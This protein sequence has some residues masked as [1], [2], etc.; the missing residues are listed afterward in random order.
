MKQKKRGAK[1]KE[2]M[3][4]EER[5]WN[6]WRF[7]STVWH[8]SSKDSIPGRWGYTSI[9]KL[10]K[11]L[12]LKY[13]PPGSKI[14]CFDES[15]DS[16][17]TSEIDLTNRIFSY[18]DFYDF[19]AMDNSE[20]T[21]AKPN[22]FNRMKFDGI[23]ATLPW[24]ILVE[25][26]W[27]PGQ[28]HEATGRF[29]SRTRSL[30]LKCFEIIQDNCFF[31]LDTRDV[32]MDHVIP[33]GTLLMQ[34]SLDAGFNLW[35]V[36][37]YDVIDQPSLSRAFS[38]FNY[39]IILQKRKQGWKYLQI[40]DILDWY[41]EE[42]RNIKGYSNARSNHNC[43][44]WNF[45]VGA[46]SRTLTHGFEYHSE[47]RYIKSKRKI[48]EKTLFAGKLV[49]QLVRKLI[50]EYSQPNDMLFD[51]FVGTGTVILE[52]VHCGRKSFGIDINPAAVE[53][54]KR[55]VHAYQE[56]RKDSQ[57][58][59]T[60]S[61]EQGNAIEGVDLPNESTDLVFIHPPYWG[62]VKYTDLAEDLSNMQLEGYLAAMQEVLREA[63]RILKSQG[64]VVVVIGDK[65][66]SGLVPLGSYLGLLGTYQGF[67]LWDLI[68]NDTEF[69]GKQ[70]NYFAQIKSKKYKFHLTDH[71]YILVF[72]KP[73]F[74]TKMRSPWLSTILDYY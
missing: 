22:D 1:K 52:G 24:W 51:F 54:T 34:Q 17:L 73:N 56:S 72:K 15:M 30:L 13:T 41:P 9:P 23:F 60:W 57:T 32:V 45:N 53:L 28:L 3:A 19:T 68:L 69:G 20:K 42:S 65:R 58:L 4:P 5:V 29:L 25:N 59:L 55:K 6:E 43:N 49:P 37:H 63:Y 21:I 10:S 61:V 62:L 47:D 71:D 74:S 27:L 31:I 48:Y 44:I 46:E 2:D 64:H 11:K 38:S 18:A 67:K 66:K 12:I 8:F 39:L 26:N 70:H 14:L 33:L 36:V 50:L 16:I 40:R 35:D 7:H